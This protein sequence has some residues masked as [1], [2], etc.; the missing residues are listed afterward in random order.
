[1]VEP[2]VTPFYK[3]M[4]LM[5]LAGLIGG[6]GILIVFSFVATAVGDTP[7]QAV[8]VSIAD[9]MVKTSLGAFI[10]LLV[11]KSI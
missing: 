4:L 9:W 3:L 11:G 5:T 1:M 7:A 8:L 6:V 10:G 2:T